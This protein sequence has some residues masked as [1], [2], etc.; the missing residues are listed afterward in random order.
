MAQVT[1]YTSPSCTHCHSAKRYLSEHGVDY[2]EVDISRDLQSAQRLID[3]TGQTGVPVIEVD[4]TM[5]VGF[6]KRRLNRALG[7]N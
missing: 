3:K 4:G 2:R 1:I 6:D 7:L 5:I